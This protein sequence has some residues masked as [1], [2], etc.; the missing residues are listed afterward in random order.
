MRYTGKLYRPPSEARSYILQATIGCSWNNCTYCDMYRDKPDFRVRPLSESL[1]DIAMAASAFGPRVDK[2]FVA[3]GDALCMPM[4]HWEPILAALRAAFPRLR[5]VSCYAMAR[6]VLEKTPAEL[7]ALRAQGLT[8]L[9][10]G[11]E[12]G[13]EQTMRELAKQPR[14][15]GV[16]R[17]RDYLFDSHVA[18]AQQAHAAGMKLSTIFLLGAGGVARSAEHAAG[19]ARL[20]T[21]MDPDY[22]AALTLTVVPGTP[23][24][25]TRHRKGWQ[26]PEIEGLLGELR[27]MV[28]DSRPSRALFRTNHASNYLP[29][30]GTLPDDRERIVQVIDL[31]LAGQIPLR[32]E[33]R[34]GL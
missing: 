30:A 6:N 17:D 20:I 7:A 16:P 28:G 4:S 19:S 25:R 2:V 32:P 5:Q 12:S 1:E 18:A 24:D 8:V 14:L 11:P 27:T 33:H 22:L 3:D 26:L 34:R 13:D 21:A 23:L 29:L 31:A 10:M 15:A 9:Y